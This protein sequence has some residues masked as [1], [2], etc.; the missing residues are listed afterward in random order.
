MEPSYVDSPWQDESGARFVPNRPKWMTPDTEF[1]KKALASVGLRYYPPKMVGDKP[2]YS[3]E[4]RSKLK[5]IGKS[6]M[7]L[8]SGLAAVYPTEWVMSVL[9]WQAKQHRRGWTALRGLLNSLNNFQWRDDFV[10]KW[11]KEH[12]TDSYRQDIE[13][14]EDFSK[15]LRMP[16][17]D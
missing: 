14:R 12:H 1:E 3:K 16:H 7:S 9:E 10:A 13:D 17:E 5:E 4:M 2:T 11:K 6:L 8:E 15:Y